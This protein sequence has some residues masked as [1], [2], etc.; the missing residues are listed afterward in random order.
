MRWVLASCGHRPIHGTPKLN[1][2]FNGQGARTQSSVTAL[3]ANL[4]DDDGNE[5][6]DL[7][8]TPDVLVVVGVEGNNDKRSGILYALDGASGSIHWATETSAQYSATPAIGDIDGDGMVEIVAV[9]PGDGARIMAFEHDGTLKWT[10]ADPW[11]A[12]QGSALALADVDADGDVEIIGGT[13]LWDHNGTLLWAQDGDRI[14]SAST[15]IDIDAD[16]ELEIL[17]GAAAYDPDGTEVFNNVAIANS[18]PENGIGAHPQV[19]DVDGDGTPEILVSVVTGMWLLETD[20]SVL[21]SS[22]APTMDAYD[23]NRPASIHDV[24][25]DGVPEFG[26]SGPYSYGAYEFDPGITWTSNKVKDVSGQ[27][28]GTAF[29]FLGAGK[30]QTIYADERK[31]WVFNEYGQILMETV[32]KSGTILEYPTVADVDNDGSAEIVVVSNKGFM[33]FANEWTVQVVGD[34]EDRWIQARRIWNQHTYHVTNV[35][36]DGTIPQFEA[37]HWQGL[38]TFRTQA[39]I[40][41]GRVCQP[42]PEG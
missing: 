10:G 11:E 2:R 32:R 36:E 5:T 13:Q 35:R 29:D 3:V 14:Y 1:G 30:A 18:S 7:C 25:A 17:T 42:K 37:R 26:A 21:W 6:I 20:G 12:A 33:A 31:T 27:A 38:N 40:E 41:G 16:G 19:A 9:E 28:G 39:Q 22:Y 4:T 23:R 15:A 24:D 34:V 8:D